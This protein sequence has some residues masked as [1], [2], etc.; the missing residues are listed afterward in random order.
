LLVG[1]G[2]GWV[3]REL[4]EDALL[5]AS[6]WRVLWAV[7][8]PR[9]RVALFAAGLWVAVQ[10]ATEITVT[11]LLQ[12]RTFA[13]EVYTQFVAPDRDPSVGD[14]RAITARAVAVS[15]PAI[16]CTWVL[17]V[18]IARRWERSLPPLRTLAAPICLF[19][20]GQARWP[21]AGVVFSL[22]GMLAGV[23][24]VSLVWKAGLHG[25]PEAWSV[26][27][28]WHQLVLVFKVHGPMVAES[29]VLAGAVGAC[30]AGAALVSCWLA[31]EARWFH[32]LVLSLAA[33]AWALPGP[34]I[35][36]GLKET[37]EILMRGEERVASAL[38][39]TGTGPLQA[40]LYAGPSLAP[41]FWV[42]L[43]RFFP[44]AVA[45]QWPVVRLLPAE[46]RDAARVDGAGPVQEFCR[47]V[48]PLTAAVWVRAAL[49]VAILSLGE[50]SAGKL[51]E[52]PGAQT[53]AHE[54]F[55]QMHYSV[56]NNVAAL[57]LVLLVLVVLGGSVWA[58]LGWLLRRPRAG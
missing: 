15:V 19:R 5:V 11:D 12:V 31:R 2:L 6:P 54:V 47:L 21:L 23:P 55:N 39:R 28:A 58:G 37:I 36:I 27:A 46:L 25:S 18:W 38:G 1:Q 44:F 22:V 13:E 33:L 50:L 3:E 20:L 34:V 24:L 57:C 16:I 49:A 26:L 52:T 35:G 30:A 56:T 43:L 7:T 32:A 9:C 42:C 10:T 29:L 14:V 41:V 51:V 4:E 8:L 17:I 40:L 45:V 53:F 48:V